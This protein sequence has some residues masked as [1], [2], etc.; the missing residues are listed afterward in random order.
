MKMWRISFSNINFL[1]TI[2]HQSLCQSSGQI[3]KKYHILTAE[4][5]YPVKTFNEKLYVCETCHTHL[6]ENEIRC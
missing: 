2:C 4:M 3:I 6:Y 5:Y 1:S